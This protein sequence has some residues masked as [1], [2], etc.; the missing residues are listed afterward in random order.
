MFV[1]K[2]IRHMSLVCLPTCPS[3]CCPAIVPAY[4]TA[5]TFPRFHSG[6]PSRVRAK[7]GHTGADGGA[8]TRECVCV[9][10]YADVN[11][12]VRR[13]GGGVRRVEDNCECRVLLE[14]GRKK[15]NTSECTDGEMEKKRCET[16]E[17]ER[18]GI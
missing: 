5:P 4:Q 11:P 8:E 2:G 9:Q 12:R 15:K 6:N 16:T 10:A 18:G 7:A 14:R 3:S 17:R 1:Y 13:G